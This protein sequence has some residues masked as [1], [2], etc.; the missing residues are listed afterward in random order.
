MKYRLYD[1][2]ENKHP[3]FDPIFYST[4]KQAKKARESFEAYEN[5]II[6]VEEDDIAEI[7]ENVHEIYRHHYW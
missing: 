7:I 4:Y 2:I 5:C 3:D 1:I 6:Y